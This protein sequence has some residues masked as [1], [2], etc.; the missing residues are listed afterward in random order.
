M[1]LG[2]PYRRGYL[3]Y[4]PPGTG[5][6]SFITALAGALH[7]NICIVS[8]QSRGLTDDILNHLLNVAPQRSILLLEDIDVAMEKGLTNVTLS[9][10]LNALDGVA[11]TEGGGRIIF[12]TTNHIERLPAALIRPG[13]VDL[14]ECLD[15]ASEMQLKR[16]FLKFYP[17]I[18][19][20]DGDETISSI[21][22]RRE[23]M[24]NDF[25]KNIPSGKISMAQLQGY[26]MQFKDDPQAAL[27]HVHELLHSKLPQPQLETKGQ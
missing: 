11:A 21:N 18:D 24:A 13:R 26:F 12:M 9:G 25:A 6:S 17:P 10:L 23:S 3:L 20:E 1:V 15:L 7:L 2:I 8:L 5:K 16:M 27:D 19:N 4:G 14:K 22:N